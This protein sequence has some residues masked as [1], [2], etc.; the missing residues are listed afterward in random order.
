MPWGKS[1]LVTNRVFNPGWHRRK[2][3][4]ETEGSYSR[5]AM[6]IKDLPWL[7][8]AVIAPHSQES[9]LALTCHLLLNPHSCTRCM[10]IPTAP[11]HKTFPNLNVAGIMPPMTFVCSMSSWSPSPLHPTEPG[12]GKGTGYGCAKS[13]LQRTV[14]GI[15][16]PAGSSLWCGWQSVPRVLL[17][18]F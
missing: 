18:S 12:K 4:A 6:A 13:K 10:R 15:F 2:Q 9:C 5:M 14:S 17:I 7:H 1:K 8:K 11:S 3:E 16:S